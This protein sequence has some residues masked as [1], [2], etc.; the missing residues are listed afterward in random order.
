MTTNEL[1]KSINQNSQH[2][3]V[4]S[5]KTINL[6]GVAA[7]VGLVEVVAQELGTTAG[8]IEGL[9]PTGPTSFEELAG[10]IVL[11]GQGFQRSLTLLA[12]PGSPLQLRFRSSWRDG[13][14]NGSDGATGGGIEAQFILDATVE[15]I[16]P[17]GRALARYVEDTVKV[18][19]SMVTLG[20]SSKLSAMSVSSA[21]I[22]AFELN[23]ADKLVA[24]NPREVGS[25]DP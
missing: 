7:F 10:E 4:G 17:Q 19:D 13:H 16:L 3:H 9:L 12:K 20:Q 22:E 2:S 6:Q 25:F 14:K 15:Q 1:L 5:G 24:N 11:N 23:E 18:L 21:E 8:R